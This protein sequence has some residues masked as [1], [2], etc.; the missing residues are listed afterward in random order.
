MSCRSAFFSSRKCSSTR[1][2]NPMQ[3]YVLRRSTTTTSPR[4]SSKREGF[5][6]AVRSFGWIGSRART[7]T[8]YAVT[9][10]LGSRGT[11]DPG[12]LAGHAK[13]A[14]RMKRA[15]V[16]IVER[17]VQQEDVVHLNAHGIELPTKLMVG[18]GP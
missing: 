1:C 12:S 4:N 14:E 15:T 18:E 2:S 16:E 11:T 17:L 8:T 9:A 10:W 7:R 13:I 5:D 3:T 6:M